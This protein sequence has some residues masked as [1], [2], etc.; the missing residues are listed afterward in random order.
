MTKPPRNKPAKAGAKTVSPTV[1]QSPAPAGT[2][3]L[4]A[5]V[6]RV[7]RIP[8]QP[9]AECEAG[10]RDTGEWV[11]PAFSTLATPRGR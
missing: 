6:E 11:R 1:R 9:R 5:L 2:R 4:G 8:H 7:V 3:D 10:A